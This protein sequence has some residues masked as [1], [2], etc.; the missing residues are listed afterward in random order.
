MKKLFIT[1]IILLALSMASHDAIAASGG[2]PAP[3]PTPSAKTFTVNSNLDADDA[4]I[5]GVCDDGAGHCTLRAAITESNAN[6]GYVDTITFASG[7]T[8][9]PSM[10]YVVTDKVIIDATSVGACPVPAVF[11]NGTNSLQTILNLENGSAG[12]VIKGLW[13]NNYKYRGV[14]LNNISGDTTTLS[15]NV[16]GLTADGL[17]AAGA[18]DSITIKNSSNILIGG[19]N[20]TDRNTLAGNQADSYSEAIAIG[21]NTNPISDFTF[22]GNYFGT[23]IN[24]TALIAD[25]T[26][27]GEG[28]DIYDNTDVSNITITKNLFGGGA[29][30][31]HNAKNIT[32]Q[33]NTINLASDGIT[34]IPLTTAFTG[35]QLSDLE[36][37]TIGGVG[38]GNIFAGSG[39]GRAIQLGQ[40]K[41]SVIQGNYFGVLPDQKTSLLTDGFKQGVLTINGSTNITVGGVLPGEGNIML[42]NG[43]QL[44]GYVNV[45]NNSDNVSIYGNKMGI[46]DDD[47][48]FP[49]AGF[50]IVIPYDAHVIIGG[51]G[52][53]QGNI[54]AGSSIGV[55]TVAN[56]VGAVQ[57]IGNQFR[58]MAVAGIVD[59]STTLAPSSNNYV[60]ILQNTFTNTHTAI[61]LAQ[62]LDGNIIPE[63][64]AGPTPNDPGDADSGPNDYLNTPIIHSVDTS[65][66]LITY[67]LDV[68]AG[69]YRVEFFRNPVYKLYGQAEVYAGFDTFVSTGTKK[70]Q[71][72]TLSLHSGD[73]VS[74]N[75]TQDL[76]GGNYGATSEMSQTYEPLP[77]ITTG[78]SS[79]GQGKPW[80]PVT[81]SKPANDSSR[82][83][84]DQLLSQNLKSGSRNGRY[85]KY[86]GGIVK[87]AKIL[88][89]HMNRLGFS[90]G[91]IDGI[92]GKLTDAAIKRMQK[93]LGTYQ[94]GMVGP[95]TRNLINNSCGTQ[96][97]Q[98]N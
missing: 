18:N 77:V 48:V 57:V 12:S 26:V 83:P 75:A 46:T 52:S 78:N 87:E 25:G 16:I 72:V 94:D 98:K 33:S 59:G 85:N 93:Y 43:N 91:P 80:T 35:F 81:V 24:G 89:S 97:L 15:C 29:I 84:V 11:I 49:F 28:I 65:S 64:Q 58:D 76:G 90:A 70:Q 19:P 95:L 17:T 32:I 31:V 1:S 68:P 40:S 42:N 66:G 63:F 41:D 21:G 3:I 74:A 37:A 73:I 79:S 50:G 27:E 20:V 56:A 67:S 61:D 53:G 9:T 5:D 4:A 30:S 6:T 47:Q 92:L 71:T 10:E 2:G 13:I 7:M 34:P 39:M 82:C 8:I 55:Y 88:Q 69:T 96:G 22:Q 45:S 54:I 36:N 51:T 14:S 86:T 44:G 62:D 38:K 60:T 23:N